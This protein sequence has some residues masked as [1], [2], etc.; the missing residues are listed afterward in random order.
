M[1][2]VSEIRA[3]LNHQQWNNDMHQMKISKVTQASADINEVSNSYKV[4]CTLQKLSSLPEY[5]R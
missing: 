4:K 3:N 2:C 1:K 5:M